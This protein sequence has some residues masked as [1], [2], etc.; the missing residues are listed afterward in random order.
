LWIVR[1]VDPAKACKDHT[2]APQDGEPGLESAIWRRAG[3]RRCKACGRRGLFWIIICELA[4]GS[5]KFRIRSAW[6][7]RRQRV[8]YFR[9]G[10]GVTRRVPRGRIG[11]NQLGSS[12]LCLLCAAADR[13]LLILAW[14]CDCGYRVLCCDCTLYNR[15]LS[16]IE[17]HSNDDTGLG[18]SFDDVLW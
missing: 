5:C 14:V 15:C 6:L 16:S 11:W 13:V 1:T 7:C 12:R 3:N 17:M 18:I 9:H 2:E 10:C 4:I 8:N